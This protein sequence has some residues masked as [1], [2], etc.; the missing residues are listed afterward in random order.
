MLSSRLRFWAIVSQAL[1]LSLIFI[2]E[3]LLGRGQAGKW[4]LIILLL[5]L[6]TALVI[7]LLRTYATKKELRLAEQ[8]RQILDAEQAED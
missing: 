6:G 8:R 5:M 3:S 4:Q 1:G 7:A 2:L